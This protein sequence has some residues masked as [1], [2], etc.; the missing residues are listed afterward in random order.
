MTETSADISS[1]TAVAE[2]VAAEPAQEET[3]ASEEEEVKPNY[4]TDDALYKIKV[5]GQ[6]KEVTAKELAE[7][8]QKES[9]A[10][11]NF[12]QASQL[13]KQ[14]DAFVDKLKTGD[15]SELRRLVGE[16][17]FR[18][19]SEEYLLGEY[20]FEQLPDEQK[21]LRRTKRENEELK[22]AQQELEEQKK[23]SENEGLKA[24]AAREIED[25]IVE[26]RHELGVDLKD[27][28][29]VMLLLDAADKA[30]RHLLQTGKRLPMKAAFEQS[31]AEIPQRLTALWPNLSK[32]EKTKVLDGLPKELK[33]DLRKAD[34]KRVKS[35]TP[36]SRAQSSDDVQATES[37][38]S[39]PKKTTW[40][41]YFKEKEESYAQA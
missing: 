25:E 33:D 28:N 38:R 5:N 32:E 21:E 8:Y 13:R 36:V 4:G 10:H 1:E 37:R 6:E 2:D 40:D 12:Q 23:H 3:K 24:K 30:E 26:L 16:K 22:R 39:R 9:A 34:V 7:R 19:M 27:T 15:L 11:Q 17:E 41:D 31:K 20:E 35:A 18:K 14:V 29:N